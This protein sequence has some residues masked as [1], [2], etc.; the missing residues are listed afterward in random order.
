V[1]DAAP[2][3]I[4][5]PAAQVVEVAPTDDHAEVTAIAALFCLFAV[6]KA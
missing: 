2:A 4:E 1:I 3:P 5:P 6:T